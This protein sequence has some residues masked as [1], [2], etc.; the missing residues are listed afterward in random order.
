[1]TYKSEVKIDQS[2]AGWQSVLSPCVFDAW[3]LWLRVDGRTRDKR[4]RGTHGVQKYAANACP[5]SFFREISPYGN[6]DPIFLACLAEQPLV[7]A[8]EA[9]GDDFAPVMVSAKLPKRETLHDFMADLSVIFSAHDFPMPYLAA[10][11]RGRPKGKSKRGQ[12]KYRPANTHAHILIA[13]PHSHARARKVRRLHSDLVE[14]LGKR[15]EQKRRDRCPKMN[16]GNF[17]WK[18]F[19][20]PVHLSRNRLADWYENAVRLGLSEI[21]EYLLKE[22]P[23]YPDNPLLMSD[24]VRIAA[25]AE[26]EAVLVELGVPDDELAGLDGL[27]VGGLGELA[28]F[29]RDAAYLVMKVKDL[30]RVSKASKR[31]A[32]RRVLTWWRE[33]M[34]IRPRLVVSTA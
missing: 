10:F 24:D 14:H 33:V 32:V 3:K 12:S 13:W 19:G 20:Q 2:I 23:D 6:P 15:N 7:Q 17:L 29:N 1:M 25:M 18:S 9:L 11:E 27:Y 21:L 26:F 31:E 4:R 22:Q 5:Y 30:M 16:P 34:G 8:F 28:L